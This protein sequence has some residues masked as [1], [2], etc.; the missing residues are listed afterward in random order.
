MTSREKLIAPI[1]F[2]LAGVLFLV[3]A[4]APALRG[5]KMNVAFLPLGIVFLVLGFAALN[6]ARRT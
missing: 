3:A 5:G 1:G 2:M 4:A 6:R